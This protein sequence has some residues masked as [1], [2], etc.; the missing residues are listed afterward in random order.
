M[1]REGTEDAPEDYVE[2]LKKLDYTFMKE[3]SNLAIETS[4]RFV[5]S[6]PQAHTA[7]V[8]TSDVNHFV[9][10]VKYASKGK[11]NEDELQMI[12]N[13]WLDVCEPAW[14]GLK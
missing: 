12:R 5:L 10:N 6:F 2:R 4:L 3:D 1:E 13:R 11:L 14:A 8:G 7:F 9:E